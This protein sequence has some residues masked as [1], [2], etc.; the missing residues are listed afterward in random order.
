MFVYQRELYHK[1]LINK[2]ASVTYNY[3]WK[4][5]EGGGG[6]GG[7]HMKKMGTLVENLEENL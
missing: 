4:P 1:K 6:G 3:M 7:C 2:L 5:E